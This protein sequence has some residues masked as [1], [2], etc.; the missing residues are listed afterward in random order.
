MDLI[1]GAPP[2]TSF[3]LPPSQQR[4][5][6]D[7]NLSEAQWLAYGFP[8]RRFAVALADDRARRRIDAD[9]SG[10]IEMR[11]GLRMMPTFPRSSLSFRTAVDATAASVAPAR[12]PAAGEFAPDRRL[13]T[14]DRMA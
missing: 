3:T 2:L 9:R 8:Y 4:R 10:R 11:T 7:M 1:I 6:Q 5:R 13:R 14:A 12:P